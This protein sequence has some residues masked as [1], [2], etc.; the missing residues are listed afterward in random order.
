MSIAA[1]CARLRMTIMPIRPSLPL[2]AAAALSLSAATPVARAYALSEVRIVQVQLAPDGSFT[3]IG[4]PLVTRSFSNGVALATAQASALVTVNGSFS[5]TNW[6]VNF[7]APLTAIDPLF[8]QYSVTFDNTLTYI[9]AEGIVTVRSTNIPYDID[10]SYSPQEAIFVLA[11]DSKTANSCEG[12]AS[13]FCAFVQNFTT[14]VPYFVAQAPAGGGGW[15]ALTISPDAFAP[16]IPEPTTYAQMLV[17]LG[18]LAG[19]F[20]RRSSML[21]RATRKDQRRVQPWRGPG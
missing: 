9:D 16:P 21:R 3:E 7:G 8:L 11:T 17:G 6:A 13:S 10:F 12:H 18:L 2:L 15:M 20:A 4:A 19:A 5:A 14:G 1:D